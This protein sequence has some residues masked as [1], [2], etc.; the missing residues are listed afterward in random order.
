[1]A[2]AMT[3]AIGTGCCHDQCGYYNSTTYDPCTGL[4]PNKH[5]CLDKFKSIFDKDDCGCKKAKKSKCGCH[6]DDMMF[7][8]GTPIY[9]DMG[10]DCPC[11]SHHGTPTFSPSGPMETY[12][13]PE[14]FDQIPGTPMPSNA[15]KPIPAPA[16]KPMPAPAAEPEP[17]PSETS[18]TI[19]PASYVVPAPLDGPSV[20]VL[21]A[22]EE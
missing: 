21:K 20:P 4:V 7:D 16:A 10:A 19:P 9:G 15:A 17:L 3:A 8:H 11:N 1:L 14:E 18:T 22:Y 2:A 13:S 12:V 5:G 6:H